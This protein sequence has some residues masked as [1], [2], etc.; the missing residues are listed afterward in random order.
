MICESFAIMFIELIETKKLL[1]DSD[2]IKQL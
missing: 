1:T 2:L